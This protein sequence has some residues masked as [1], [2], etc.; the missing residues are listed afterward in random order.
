M[1]RSTKQIILLNKYATVQIF[2]RNEAFIIL[3]ILFDVFHNGFWPI[4]YKRIVLSVPSQIKL[5]QN[6]YLFHN[7][8][9]LL[10]QLNTTLEDV[11]VKNVFV[12]K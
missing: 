4:C 2:N 6:K 5:A 1:Q 10:Y 3:R 9:Q 12:R 7:I 8:T 11:Y